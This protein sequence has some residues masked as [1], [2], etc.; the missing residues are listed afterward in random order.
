M[1]VKYI[2]VFVA[3]W[4]LWSCGKDTFNPI[5]D[6]EIPM[7]ESRLSITA[8]LSNLD[9]LVMVHVSHT[10]GILDNK[11]SVPLKDAIVSLYEDG[12]Q[13]VSQFTYQEVGLESTGQGEVLIQDIFISDKINFKAGM[14]YTLKVEDQ[15]Y[16]VSET[17]QY[18]PS[19]IPILS[20]TYQADG[21]TDVSGNRAN[22][23]ALSFQDNPMEKNYYLASVFLATKDSMQQVIRA[24]PTISPAD[25]IAKKIEKGLLFSDATFDGQQYT[26]QM[27]ISNLDIQEGDRLYVQLY[28]ISEDRYLFEQG[29]KTYED[30]AEN[31]FAEPIILHEN[32]DNGN[33]IF[34]LN[35][36]S[37]FIIKI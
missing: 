37:Q 7:H 25:P 26:L 14:A 32:I 1:K 36:G 27:A 24:F 20:A 31:P 23:I 4:S 18:F 3:L 29:V 12:G 28:T 11:P 19:E 30:S 16:G 13:L 35:A 33:G 2:Y 34:T 22:E 17:I 6:L 9:S 21:V 8:H 10:A 15:D 5:I